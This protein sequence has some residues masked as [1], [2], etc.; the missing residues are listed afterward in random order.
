MNAYE[1]ISRSLHNI[2]GIQ[3][4]HYDYDMGETIDIA[5]FTPAEWNSRAA[6]DF[7]TKNVKHWFLQLVFDHSHIDGSVSVS[8]CIMHIEIW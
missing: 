6:A 3:I 5:Y 8:K 1:L 4:S 7:R 2:D